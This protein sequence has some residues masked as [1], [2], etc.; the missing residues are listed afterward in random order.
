MSTFSKDSTLSAPN[1]V[2]FKTTANGAPN[3]KYIDLL[4]EDKPVAGQRFT[5]ISFISPEKII[6][7]RELYNFQEFLKQWDMHKSLEKFNQFLSFL[8]PKILH[9]ETLLFLSYFLHNI[10]LLPNL[11][12]LHHQ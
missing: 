2:E 8:Y 11:V 10:F 4:D 6:K 12:H 9:K 7:Q 3:P 5:C 1:G